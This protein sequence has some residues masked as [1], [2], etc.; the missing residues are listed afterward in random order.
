M[1][2]GCNVM[3]SF[4]PR[5]TRTPRH[6]RTHRL[7]S[8]EDTRHARCLAD[9]CTRRAYYG[10]G[11]GRSL[12]CL[13][14]KLPSYI[15]TCSKRC[16]ATQDACATTN[17]TNNNN[18][19]PPNN[20]TPLSEGRSPATSVPA[21]GATSV[22]T[23]V[24][25]SV[26]I[27]GMSPHTPLGDALCVEPHAEIQG[28]KFPSA[29]GGTEIGQDGGGVVVG[30]CG[31]A[32]D[33]SCRDAMVGASCGGAA[34]GARSG[35]ASDTTCGNDTENT[36]QD[37]IAVAG[38]EL[39][40]WVVGNKHRDK[41]LCTSQ[42]CLCCVWPLFMAYMCAM[43]VLQC[44]NTVYGLCVR[45]GSVA[46]LHHCVWPMCALWQCCSVAVLQH[47]VWPCVRYG[48]VAVLQCCNSVY[49]LCVRYGSVAA[50]QCCNSVYGLHVHY[51]TVLLMYY[52]AFCLLCVR[53]GSVAYRCFLP[54][55]CA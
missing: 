44:C 13:L 19:T 6:C 27:G 36:G 2:V 12:T 45:Y 4:G 14:H 31:H 23:L 29:Q 24:A 38:D 53:D 43:A 28:G 26:T 25:R 32:T 55:M 47:C 52:A 1:A 35:N 54:P 11:G 30:R 20:G 8:E 41:T 34:D 3:A 33:P 10:E 15:D 9:G 7:E 37:A 40:P 46:V 5:L 21:S 51:L 16:E 22:A 42:V 48:S 17:H 18:A 39:D 50:L 49:G